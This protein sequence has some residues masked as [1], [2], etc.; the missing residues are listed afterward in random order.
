MKH[1]LRREFLAVAL[2]LPLLGGCASDMCERLAISGDTQVAKPLV[3]PEGVP[4][5]ADGGEYRVPEVPAS[6]PVAG[7]LAE[8]PMTLPPE[9]LV[10]PE[11]GA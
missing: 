11:E 4:A 7:C 3:L 5:I 1:F 8:P 6:A 9:V 2:V 10:E